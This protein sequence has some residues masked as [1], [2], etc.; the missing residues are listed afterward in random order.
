LTTIVDG[1]G[2]PWWIAKE[3]CD[4]LGYKNSPDA[5][6]NQKLKGIVKRDTLGGPQTVLIIN[7]SDLY[8]LII[9]SHL[10][11]AQ[12]FEKWIMEKVIPSIRKTGSYSVTSEKPVSYIETMAR[13]MLAAGKVVEQ[14]QMEIKVMKPKVEAYD[15]FLET[16]G[17]YTPQRA[18][19]LLGTGSTRLGRALRHG[20][21]WFQ[22]GIMPVQSC[23][24]AGFFEVKVVQAIPGVHRQSP[25]SCL[26]ST[27]KGQPGHR[28][29]YR[30]F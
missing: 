10:P 5:V 22:K 19:K 27:R 14:L 20:G 16:D 18:A 21:I 2:N 25:G 6:N 30:V 12:E 15:Q 23:V 9:G 1:D 13:G 4:V 26:R 11:A 29:A 8:R 7:E 17:L 3:V 28:S 24:D